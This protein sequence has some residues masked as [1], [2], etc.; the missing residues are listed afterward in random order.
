MK[1]TNKSFTLPVASK[2]VTDLQYDIAVG[3][4]CAKC[5]KK[6]EKCKCPR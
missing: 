4:R 5:K 1:Y 6:V 2:K 3:R